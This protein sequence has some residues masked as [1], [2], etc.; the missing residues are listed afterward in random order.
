MN[1]G[2]I[3]QDEN[4]QWNET[5]ENLQIWNKKIINEMLTSYNQNGFSYMKEKFQSDPT[6]IQ[7]ISGS[8]TFAILLLQQGQDLPPTFTWRTL[9]NKDIPMN[10]I[11]VIGLGQALFSFLSTNYFNSFKHKA[12]ID[13]LT[14]IQQLLDYD[15]TTGW[16]DT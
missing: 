3:V 14:D 6:S 9:D 13:A 2:Y 1:P 4:S 16:V 15:A 12:N 5:V 11:Q 8:V 7:N 10:A